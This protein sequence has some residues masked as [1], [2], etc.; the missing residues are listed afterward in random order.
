MTL[1]LALILFLPQ[2]TQRSG[3]RTDPDGSGRIGT[4]WDGFGRI[5]TDL[6]GMGAD[7]DEGMTDARHAFARLTP[8][9][10]MGSAVPV[11]V[12]RGGA[13]VS[14]AAFCFFAIALPPSFPCSVCVS[15]SIGQGV[16]VG[17]EWETTLR[18]R[19]KTRW[20]CPLASSPNPDLALS[21]KLVRRARL[22]RQPRQ[23]ASCCGTRATPG[24]RLAGPRGESGARPALSRSSLRLPPCTG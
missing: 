6:D 5:W 12:P 2:R 10:P 17:G 16:A 21:P 9:F 1:W 22:V 8:A 23:S 18:Y 4:D 14:N 7:L 13:G 11:P 20:N 15:F 3:T 19:R 24:G